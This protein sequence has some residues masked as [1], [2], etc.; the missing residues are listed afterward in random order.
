MSSDTLISAPT[1]ERAVD[2]SQQA[3]IIEPREGDPVDA[4]YATFSWLP[5]PSADGYVFQVARDETFTD[6]VVDVAVGDATSL[7]LFETFRPDGNPRYARVAATIGASELPY[8][9]VVM[10]RPLDDVQY[11]KSTSRPARRVAPVAQRPTPPRVDSPSSAEE[12]SIVVPYRT[13]TTSSGLAL[14]VVLSILAVFALLIGIT[15]AS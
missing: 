9:E 7:T 13:A 2:P 14:T 6:F 5:V 4:N 1:V 12:P 3:A 11:D 10:F 15:L 8:S